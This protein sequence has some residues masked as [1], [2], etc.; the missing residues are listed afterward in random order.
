M[1][2]PEV[3]EEIPA[4]VDGITCAG[5]GVIFDHSGRGRPPKKCP[6]CRP[7]RGSRATPTAPTDE[8][9]PKRPRSIDALQRN[10]H[11]QL[12][13]LG[14]GLTMFD[15]FDGQVVIKNAE[16]GATSLSNL[17][18]TNPKI[19]AALESTVEGAGYL[20]VAMWFTSTILPILA[21]HGVLRGVPDPARSGATSPAPDRS[22][23]FIPV[24]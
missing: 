14:M 7:V 16:K 4:V 24:G 2:A 15:G 1:T 13:M 8:T 6:D 17:A 10:I 12:V 3:D 18:A 21:H 5:C 22:N 20:P 23:P 11:Q 9:P 19:R